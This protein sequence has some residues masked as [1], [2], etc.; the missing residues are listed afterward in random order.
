MD[1]ASAMCRL[2]ERL[3]IATVQSRRLEITRIWAAGLDEVQWREPPQ[4]RP[5]IVIVS[6]LLASPTIHTV[7]LATDLD[8]LLKRIG[9]GPLTLLYTNSV[10]P[11]KN[12]HFPPFRGALEPIGLKL[13][14]DEI[15]AIETNRGTRTL[16]YA[17]FYRPAQDTLEL[18]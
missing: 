6:Y 13:I 4:W 11:D 17:L 9:R 1:R 5:V 12:V 14:K 15:G 16:R 18:E 7:A 3:A 10:Y 8:K 2:G